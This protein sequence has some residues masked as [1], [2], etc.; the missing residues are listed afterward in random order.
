VRD[1]KT[2]AERFRIGV[3]G[4]WVNPQAAIAWA[5]SVIAA[6]ARP[7]SAFFD[8]SSASGR[9]RSELSILLSKVPGEADQ[10]EVMRRCLGDLGAWVDGDASRGRQAA[11]YIYK[12][13][14][15]GELA[16]DFFGLEPFRLCDAFSLADAE[17]TGSREEAMA[18]LV[19]FLEH[20]GRVV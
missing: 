18:D 3:A 5:D 10:V 19:R 17:V 16:E 15:S 4:G 20:Y 12:A 1:L 14:C 13:A 9:D 2:D 11:E 7:E 8:I 6:E